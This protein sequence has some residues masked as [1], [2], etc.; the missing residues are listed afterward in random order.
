MTAGD[1]HRS[2]GGEPVNGDAW[3]EL[4]EGMAEEPKLEGDEPY[5][6]CFPFVV[7]STT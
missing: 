1:W 5:K 6:M 3:E 4:E 7:W 2:D